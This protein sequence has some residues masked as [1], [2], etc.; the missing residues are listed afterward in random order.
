MGSFPVVCAHKGRSTCRNYKAYQAN[1]SFSVLTHK[2]LVYLS[3]KNII[4]FLEVFI[5]FISQRLY[6]ESEQTILYPSIIDEKK[7]IHPEDICDK[8]AIP[9]TL[10]LLFIKYLGWL[11]W[12]VELLHG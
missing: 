5:A 12:D 11:D 10:S 2:T 6:T 7:F 4:S 1:Y 8:M 9:A 3:H